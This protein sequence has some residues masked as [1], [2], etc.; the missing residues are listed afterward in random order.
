MDVSDAVVWHDL[1][2]GSYDADLALWRELADAAAAT[3]RTSAADAG[4]GWVLELGAGT[5]RVSLQLARDGHRVWALDRDR[6]LLAALRERAAAASLDRVETVC[7]DARDFALGHADFA[8]CVVPMQT[9]QLLGGAEGRRACLACAGRHL[10]DGGLLACAIVTDVE[11][12]DV[13][14]GGRGPSAERGRVNGTTYVSR[15]TLV[16]VNERVVRIERER[17]ISSRA[18]ALD[19]VELDLV[20]IGQLQR[21]GRAAGLTPAG[22]RTIPET[23]EHAGSAVV[24]FHA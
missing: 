24:V 20:S 9:L 10:T 18:P 16:E 12:F 3:A 1:E 23:R 17:T 5:G 15:P 7:A 13:R 19:V 4:G 14:A 11:P 8:L 21:D 22:T 2:C 6:E